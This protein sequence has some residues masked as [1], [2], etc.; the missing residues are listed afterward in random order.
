MSPETSSNGAL[1]I[2][3]Q[4]GTDTGVVEITDKVETDSGAVETIENRDKGLILTQVQA[5]ATCLHSKKEGAVTN[6]VLEVSPAILVVSGVVEI[7]GK[8]VE[9]SNNGAVE[10]IDQVETGSG[11][12][13]VEIGQEAL[14]ESCLVLRTPGAVEALVDKGVP[15][16]G[17]V[18]LKEIEARD[19]NQMDLSLTPGK[20]QQEAVSQDLVQVEVVQAEVEAGE[21]QER[22]EIPGL[23]LNS[24]AD[25]RLGAWAPLGIVSGVMTGLLRGAGPLETI[26][27]IQ[28]VR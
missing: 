2:I 4:V 20:I 23:I 6:G 7:I 21:D 25:R 5:G 15:Q 3:D 10:T 22:R 1:E 18:D 17:V 8:V 26:G 14:V 28:V 27:T 16:T 9:T 13:G 24:G 12:K 11:V 19:R